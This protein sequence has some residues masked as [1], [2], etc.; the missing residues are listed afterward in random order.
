MMNTIEDVKSALIWNGR[1][2]TKPIEPDWDSYQVESITTPW[3][4]KT[5]QATFRDPLLAGWKALVVE[6][7][8]P[9]DYPGHSDD[10]L[11]NGG[12]VPERITT[13]VVRFPRIILPEFNTHRVF[14]RN[15]ASSR[16]RSFKTTIKPIMTD[17]F[18]P[19][20]T[21]NQKGMGGR[22]ADGKTWEEAAGYWLQSR[23]EAVMGTLRLLAGEKAL[24]DRLHGTR[25][26]LSP[27]DMPDHWEAITD[28]YMEAYKSGETDGIPSIHKQDANRLLEPFMWHE[29]LVTS[30][31]WQ[32]FLDLRISEY[33]QPEIKALAI[34]V[35]EAL[36]ASN[37]ETSWIHLPFGDASKINKKSWKSIEDAMLA[38]ASECARI[39]YK[40]RSTMANKD[41]SDLGRRLLS[42]RHMSPFEHI[43]VDANHA[44]NVSTGIAV[45]L[46]EINGRD[47]SSNLSPEWIQF[48]RIVSAREQ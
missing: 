36:K 15:S 46:D 17:P 22:F 45:K 10:Y 11:K 34:L 27:S 8:L 39:S 7:T 26:E 24:S 12:V 2:T 1:D 48:R 6:D 29:T 3:G 47:L 13:M 44:S 32:N 41:G 35:R 18:I 37:P 23:N 25:V 38:S 28:A 43:A 4:K 5:V 40:D 9:L 33:A 20:F 21:V 30:T 16:A 14:S 31:Y 19:L 42:Q